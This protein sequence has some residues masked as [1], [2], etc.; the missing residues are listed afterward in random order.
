[1]QKRFNTL[2]VK[3]LLRHALKTLQFKIVSLIYD[4]KK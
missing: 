1:M 3:R 4:E 2:S